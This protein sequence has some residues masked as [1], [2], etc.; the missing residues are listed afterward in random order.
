MVIDMTTLLKRTFL[1]LLSLLFLVC[2]ANCRSHKDWHTASRESAEI[3]PPAGSTNEAVLHVYGASAWGWRGWFAIHTWIAAK[4]TGEPSYTVYEVIGW[5]E[6]RGLPVLRIAKDYPDRNWFGEKPRLLVGHQGEGVD[7]LI[8][9]VEQAAQNYPWKTNYKSFPGP[10]SNS[11]TAWVAKEVPA[12]N[13]KLPFSAI[14][15]GFVE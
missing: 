10:N 1:P 3:A 14:G 15:S 12:L 11:F 6:N 5:R 2:L 7:Q 9:A 4:H 13:L 8:T